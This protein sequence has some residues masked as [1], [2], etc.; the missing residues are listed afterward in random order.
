MILDQNL[1]RRMEAC[2]T[3]GGADYI[4]TDKTGTLTKNEMTI[5]K[6]YDGV[7]ENEMNNLYTSNFNG[8]PTDIFSQDFYDLFKL[9]SSCNTLTEVIIILNSFLLQEKRR[10]HLKLI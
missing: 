9:V 6:I 2:E 5:V 4:C 1:V 10:Q 3:M 7:T 8:K